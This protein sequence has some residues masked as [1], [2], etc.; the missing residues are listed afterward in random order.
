MMILLN[1]LQPKQE[2]TFLCAVCCKP[3]IPARRVALA[4]V[5]SRRTQTP[6][7]LRLCIIPS[8]HIIALTEKFYVCWLR[9]RGRA[10]SRDVLA[11]RQL[12]NQWYRPARL[13]VPCP[14]LYCRSPDQP[15]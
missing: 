1:G 15:C 7:N 6:H 12:K 13:P 5:T 2:S 9:Q 11:H 8:M 4:L 10:G 3:Q 14:D